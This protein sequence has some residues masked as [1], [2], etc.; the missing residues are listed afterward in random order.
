[1]QEIID[2]GKKQILELADNSFG[3]AYPN[4]VILSEIEVIIPNTPKT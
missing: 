4:R 1:V 3:T 2:A